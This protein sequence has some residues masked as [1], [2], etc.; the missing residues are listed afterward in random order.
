MKTIIDYPAFPVPQLNRNSGMSL[1][2]YAAIHLRVADS[3][4]VWL[5]DMI[6]QANAEERDLLKHG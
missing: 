1:R 4:V 5:D 6:T 3:G 2:T